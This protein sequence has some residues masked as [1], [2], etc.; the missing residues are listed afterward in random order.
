VLDV[1]EP[2]RGIVLHPAGPRAVTQEEVS[3]LV[4]GEQGV[5]PCGETQHCGHGTSVLPTHGPAVPGPS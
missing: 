5:V 1:V 3:G 2:A 4:T